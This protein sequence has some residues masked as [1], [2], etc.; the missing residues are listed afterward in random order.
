MLDK[1]KQ[2][3]HEFALPAPGQRF[4]AHY[5]Q[6]QQQRPSALHK[7][8]LAIGG[9]ILIMG[10]GLFFLLAPGPGMLIF[11]LGAMLVAQESFLGARWMD[12]LDLRLRPLVDWV[13]SRWRRWRN[14]VSKHDPRSG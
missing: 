3:W 2:R 7:K 10:A 12:W 1:L 4:K 14:R 6:R 5:Q 8:I 11:L 13:W 9:G